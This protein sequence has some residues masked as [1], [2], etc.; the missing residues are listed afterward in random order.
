MGPTRGWAR[1]RRR[2]RLLRTRS[3]NGALHDDLPVRVEGVHRV[4][5][6]GVGRRGTGLVTAGSPSGDEVGPVVSTRCSCPGVGRPS[7][8]GLVPGHLEVDEVAIAVIRQGIEDRL[9]PALRSP[10]GGRQPHHDAARAG[11]QAVIEHH[12][13]S[14]D[15]IS[16]HSE[17]AHARWVV[18]KQRG[19]SRL[20]GAR[21]KPRALEVLDGRRPTGS[22]GVV[23]GV[24]P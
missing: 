8:A 1:G 22:R 6:G 13:L 15:R 23:T 2:V 5:E 7:G 19:G 14:E 21:H 18:T 3:L 10:R 12:P 9:R 16:L 4:V 24:T 20:R 17:L 11:R